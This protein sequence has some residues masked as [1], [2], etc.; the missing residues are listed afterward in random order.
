MTGD[1][2]LGP[3]R[4]LAGGFLV[5]G[6]L[7]ALVFGQLQFT[8]DVTQKGI[9]AFAIGIVLAAAAALFLHRRT[10]EPAPRAPALETWEK[11][12]LVASFLAAAALRLP[13]LDRFPPGGFFD[14]SQNVL[15]AKWILKG[16]WPIFVADASQMPA[17]YFYLVAAAVKLLGTSVAAIRALS[18]LCG[19]LSIP[20]F[21]LLARRFFARE[22]AVAATILFL[23][24]RWHLNFSRIGFN[25]IMSPLMEL[26]TLL[27]LVKALETGR[28][29]PWVFFG[30][31]VA[32][33]LQTYYAFNLFP[34]VFVATVLAFTLRAGPRAFGSEAKRVI[35][36]LALA[37]GVAVLLL[38][39]LGIFALRNRQVFFQ[40]AGT[41]A[42]WNPAHGLKM[43]DALYSNVRSHLLMFSY[44]GDGN[45]RH[46]IQDAPL[47][48]P[49]ESVL[50]AFGL[51]C[52][53]GR[54]LRWPRP[55]FLTWFVVMLL[56]GILTIEAPQAYRTIGVIP[57]LFFLIGEGLQTLVKLAT[58]R[59]RPSAI[60]GAWLAALALTAAAWDA[61]IYFDVQVRDPRAWQAF[62]ADHHEIARFLKAEAAGHQNFIDPSFFDVPTF[63]LYLGEEFHSSRFRLSDHIPVQRATPDAAGESQ[64]ALFV[65]DGAQAD[66]VP[67]FRA[68]YPHAKSR[69]HPDRSGRIMF[70]SIEVPAE[71]RLHPADNSARGFLA[72]FHQNEDWGG[73]PALVRREPA[74]FFHY[75]WDQ[76]AIPPP[77]TVDWA[78]RLQV[79]QSG[80]YGFELLATGPAE[81]VVDGRV[82]VEQSRF[83]N[84]D[85]LTGS[86]PLSAGPHT[87]VVRYL[88]K[89]Y[90]ATIRLWWRPPGARRHSVIPLRALTATSQDESERLK[91]T[92]PKPQREH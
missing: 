78:A 36:G 79:D 76:D 89:S 19:S 90:G 41:V 13:A 57:A 85:P 28:K 47:F 9:P 61:V 80:D 15:V 4:R 6:S 5:L 18:G 68:A 81:V 39:P 45:P 60:L 50:L 71:D 73:E 40:R 86:M 56:P 77:F 58:S 46:N 52:A 3:W 48:T 59:D 33:G 34:A 62:E 25:G 22:V 64:P 21:Y 37:V 35:G 92:L 70:V 10:A 75:H 24:C 1:V 38:L 14:E 42:I 27:A 26:L 69:L 11:L 23:G 51:G 53:L 65:L 30:A 20:V 54:G 44:H 67:I 55:I 72:S 91:T 2:A 82:L 16:N 17:L 63:H 12:F 8:R 66:L 84:F 43:P 83:E 32:V 74:V 29:L 31:G 88:Q 7:G 49:I 87:L